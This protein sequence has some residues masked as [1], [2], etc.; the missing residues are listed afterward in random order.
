MN[1]LV[2][3]GMLPQDRHFRSL[4]QQLDAGAIG[5][6]PDLLLSIYIYIYII[7]ICICIYI[8]IFI[9]I[10]IYH[11]SWSSKIPP[12]IPLPS[13]KKV[14]IGLKSALFGPHFAMGVVQKGV[15]QKSMKQGP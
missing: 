13:R 1:P 2:A 14:Q 10:Y 3:T 15:S 11:G 6:Q 8:Y 7:Y 5:T 12:S 9:C 4:K